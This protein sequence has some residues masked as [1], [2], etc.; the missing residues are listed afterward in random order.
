VFQDKNDSWVEVNRNL[1]WIENGKRLL[2]TS[3]RDGWRHVYAITR[4]GDAR[5][6]TNAHR[7]RGP[8]QH[9]PDGQDRITG[10]LVRSS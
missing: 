7:V 4:E 9:G 1:K 2:F 6:V 3:E 8:A 5:L 10:P